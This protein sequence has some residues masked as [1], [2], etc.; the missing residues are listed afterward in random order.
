ME[1]KIVLKYSDG[2]EVEVA[3]VVVTL[4]KN[5]M[6]EVNFKTDIGIEYTVESFK[7]V[8]SPETMNEPVREGDLLGTINAACNKLNM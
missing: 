1:P 4:Q 2:T 5:R 3:Y 8:H 7:I 6:P